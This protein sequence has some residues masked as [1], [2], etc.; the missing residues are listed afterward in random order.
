[1]RVSQGESWLKCVC[2]CVYASVTHP[3]LAEMTFLMYL[4]SVPDVALRG[5]AR[6]SALRLSHSVLVRPTT[7]ITRRSA[8]MSITSPFCTHTSHTH[9]HTYTSRPSHPCHTHSLAD[10]AI[11]TGQIRV[12]SHHPADTLLFIYTHTNWLDDTHDNVSTAWRMHA[13]LYVWVHI[14]QRSK[15]YLDQSQGSPH[16]CLRR[17]VTNDKPV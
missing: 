4:Y 2:V 3:S 7:S 14:G 6:H 11:T 15:T 13:V 17:H 9:T 8:S 12:C 1:M 16:L 10:C 5:G